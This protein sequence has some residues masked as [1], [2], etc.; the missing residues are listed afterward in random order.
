M[1]ATEFRLLEY[2]MVNKNKVISRMDIL[3]EVWE[4]DINM[5]TNVVDV[6]VNYLRKK[7]DKI[8]ENKLIHT[9]IGL[10]YVMRN[11]N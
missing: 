2:L 11:E 4:M 9:V 6:Y 8:Y 10:G 7:I 1:T 3:E 5:S